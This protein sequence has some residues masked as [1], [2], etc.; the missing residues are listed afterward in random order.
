LKFNKKW[1]SR[2][3]KLNIH[4]LNFFFQESCDTADFELCKKEQ[5]DFFD[6]KNL[7]SANF[8]I[9]AAQTVALTN[10]TTLLSKPNK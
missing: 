3:N 4:V 10:K 9:V 5:P 1:S 7:T 6:Q 2:K 8:K